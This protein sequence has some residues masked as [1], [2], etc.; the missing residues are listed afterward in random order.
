MHTTSASLLMRLRDPGQ[1]E[2]WSRFVRLYSPLLY[3]W[4]RRMGLQDADAVDL[5]QE[6]FAALLKKL[7]E[8]NYDDHKRFRG[9]LWTVTRNKWLEL[10][11]PRRLPI[12]HDSRPEHLLSPEDDALDEKDFYRHLLAELVPSVQAHFQASTWRAFWEHVVNEKPPAQVAAELGISLASVYHAKV[13][14]LARLNKE[15]GHL[16]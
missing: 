10:T 14:V 9:W 15:L 1:A 3:S 2:A 16:M 11:R 13:R 7:P 12:D 4:S 5:A 6:V 8:F